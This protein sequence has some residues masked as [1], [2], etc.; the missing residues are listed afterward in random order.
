METHL[1]EFDL[2]EDTLVPLDLPMLNE[3][4]QL[5]EKKKA[6]KRKKTHQLENQKE[7]ALKHTMFM[8]EILKL[9]KLKK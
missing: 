3:G 4:E 7:G 2:Y 6:K 5:D 1:G 9:K 8:L